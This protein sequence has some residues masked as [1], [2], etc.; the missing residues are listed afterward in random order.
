MQDYFNLRF[1]I[2][3]YEFERDMGLLNA[4]KVY[5]PILTVFIY[6][7]KTSTVL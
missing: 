4:T 3:H 1:R 7:S 2:H 6:R 5:W